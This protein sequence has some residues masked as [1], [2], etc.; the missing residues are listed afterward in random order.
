M[1]SCRIEGAWCAGGWRKGFAPLDVFVVCISRILRSRRVGLLLDCRPLQAVRS[2]MSA[3]TAP[4]EPSTTTSS[5]T[6][7]RASVAPTCARSFSRRSGRAEG[8]NARSPGVPHCSLP[9]GLFGPYCPREGRAVQPL[10]NSYGRIS[11]PRSCRDLRHVTWIG[12]H[13]GWATCTRPA[14][15]GAPTGSRARSPRRG[16][17]APIC[18]ETRCST[19]F[20]ASRSGTRG[21]GCSRLRRTRPASWPYARVRASSPH[22]CTGNPADRAQRLLD[23]LVL[24]MSEVDAQVMRKA[25]VR[26]EQVAGRDADLL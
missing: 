25:M 16:T 5:R 22:Q 26:G 13:S 19:S 9:H 11:V 6:R 2:T 15:S 17:R 12:R 7:I 8:L 23:V 4:S 24:R 14:R 10:S 3:P 18:C 20:A 21:G 1:C